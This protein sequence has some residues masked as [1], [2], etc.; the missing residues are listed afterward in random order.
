MKRDPEDARLLASYN[1]LVAEIGIE[2]RGPADPYVLKVLRGDATV[3][4]DMLERHGY[5]FEQGLP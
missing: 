5:T 4:R 1:H 3:I 2:E